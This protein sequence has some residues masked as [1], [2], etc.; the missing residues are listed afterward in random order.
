MQRQCVQY[1]NLKFLCLFPYHWMIWIKKLPIKYKQKHVII[2]LTNY[3][4]IEECLEL[5]WISYYW[6]K[7][8]TNNSKC[9]SKDSILFKIY[10]SSKNPGMLHVIDSIV[11]FSQYFISFVIYNL[12][13]WFC[14]I[15]YYWNFTGIVS[16]YKANCVMVY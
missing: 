3:Q 12:N 14:K 10:M 8:F 5:S 6:K 15:I 13:V 9:F 7:K 16:I 4:C 11:I 1:I 2:K